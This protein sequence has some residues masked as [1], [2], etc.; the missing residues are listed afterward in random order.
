M[1]FDERLRPR[2]QRLAHLL[3]DSRG[4]DILA[5]FQRLAS[6][7]RADTTNRLATQD[8]A[9]LGV[10]QAERDGRGVALRRREL[11]PSKLVGWADV[12]FV[13]PAGDARRVVLVGESSARGLDC[14]DVL[15]RM[16][17][18]AAP[19][20]FQCV[21]LMKT[22]GSVEE[23]R[24]LTGQLPLARPEVVV[25]VAGNDWTGPPRPIAPA[26]RAI[27]GD[28]WRAG[29]YAALR[30][31]Y[32]TEVVLPRTRQVLDALVELH[33]AG[34]PRIVV[35]IPEFNLPG[36]APPADIEVPML[37]PDALR[38]WYDL[39]DEAVVARG[40]RRFTD[41]ALLAERLRLLDG[42]T[43]PIPGYLHATAAIAQ[44]DGKTARAGLEDSR[45]TL[46]GLGVW[47]TPRILRDVQEAL[48]DL[49]H[50]HDFPCVDLRVVLDSAELPGM[51]SPDYLYSYCH[52]SDHGMEKAM[53]AIADAVLD[54]PT[55]STP[56]GDGI[57]PEIRGAA[58]LTAAVFGALFGNPAEL[59]TPRLRAAVAADP[60]VTEYLAA[61]LDVLE[62]FGPMWCHAGIRTLATSPLAAT[63]FGP[64]LLKS[65]HA[66]E[67]WT[68]RECLSAVL[69]RAPATVPTEV[70]LLA[71]PEG[72]GHRPANQGAQR[73]YRQAT[74][75]DQTLAFALDQPRP[76]TL[77]LTYRMPNAPRGDRAPVSLNDR[78]IGTLTATDRWSG[79]EFA[80]PQ[81][82]TRVG[83]NRVRV[84]W[85]VPE[86]DQRR[87]RDTETAAIGRG[88]AMRVLPVFGELFEALVSI[89]QGGPT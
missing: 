25:L 81:N 32:V 18:A 72:P 14:T 9:H 85:P 51:P 69:G 63:L 66:P 16:L 62:G 59:V 82:A 36:W 48:A 2:A 5:E 20:G 52:L 38:H 86:V 54:H 67:L 56:T 50:E 75:R 76:G 10:W 80:L 21:N 29:G 88:A 77:Q 70:D 26:T 34:G 89:R 65:D 68:L 87:W 47:H 49:A 44:N 4:A 31:A 27:L 79:V 12:D 43:S 3:A 78:P 41:V 19:G 73:G 6:A 8:S 61:L 35:M 71:A 1:T 33:S 37:E 58:H 39:Y 22:G 64:Q 13:P 83:V 28:A 42:G 23:L 40:E 46:V 57:P 84:R 45:D 74:T 60:R 15:A 7:Q 17:D 55:G 11:P 53:A 24:R 30:R